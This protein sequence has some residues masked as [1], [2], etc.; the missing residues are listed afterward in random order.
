MRTS[1]RLPA[2]LPVAALMAAA[3][4]EPGFEL[5]IEQIT[6]G[7]KNHFFGYI[8]HAKNIPWN[9]NERYIVALETEFQDRMPRAAD[10]ANV[11]LID[12][13]RGNA[14]TVIDRTR[15]W[16]FQQG[17]MFYW[18]PEA[19]DTQLFFN[20]RDPKTNHVFAVLYD[21]AKKKRLREFRYADTPFGNSGV[22]QKGGYFLGLNYGRLARL[23][24]VTGYPES[25]DWNMGAAAPDNDGVFLVEVKTGKK[26]LLVSYQ[27]M[28]EVVKPLAP[29]ADTVELFVN[30][31]LW[32]RDGNLIYFYVRGGYLTRDKTVNVPCSI[33]PDGTGLTAHKTFIGGHPEWEQGS[34]IIGA[35][36]GNMVLYDVE[37]KQLAGTV[38]QAD[39]WVKASGD[40]ALSPD[41]QWIV[42]GAETKAGNMYVAFRR[43]DSATARSRAFPAPGLTE[44]DLRVDGSPCWNRSSNAFLFPA[45]A[46]D[47]QRTRQLF[48]ARIVPK[49]GN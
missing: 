30:H 12:T 25:F 14:I 5:Q 43:S 6:R 38:G 46:D 4:A 2:T 15:A 27:Q 16:N 1:L 42:N 31:T 13:R 36:D 17:T 34:R 41:G 44:G 47:P 11:I 29:K 19:P 23:R 20:D 39:T 21:I 18:N 7:P 8:G 32:N 48:V 24:P 10:A 3:A 26:R 9:G 22:A 28:L 45:I 35:M 49:A 33:R 37:R 40:V